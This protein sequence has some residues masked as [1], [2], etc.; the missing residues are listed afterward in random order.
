MDEK[1]AG[2]AMLG[3]ILFFVVVGVGVGIF[4]EQPAIGGI[5]GGVLGILIGFWLVPGL[6]NDA[7]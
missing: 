6:I 5:G 3:T 1:A 7:Q 4:F 2:V